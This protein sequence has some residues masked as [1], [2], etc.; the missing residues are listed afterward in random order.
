MHSGGS[1]TGE[2][3]VGFEK[4]EF[5]P[6]MFAEPDLATMQR[7]RAAFDPTGICN[8]EK[9]FPRPRL[10]AERRGAYVPHPLETAGVAEIY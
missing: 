9:I 3:G 4:K 2:H 10:C 7:V 8:P 5:M 1:I 6:E